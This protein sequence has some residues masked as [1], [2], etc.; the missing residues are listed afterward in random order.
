M[1]YLSVNNRSLETQ[2]RKLNIR[3]LTKEIETVKCQMPGHQRWRDRKR[4]KSERKR[5][6]TCSGCDSSL[7]FVVSSSEQAMETSANVNMLWLKIYW[8]NAHH[9]W[10]TGKACFILTGGENEEMWYGGRGDALLREI[11]KGKLRGSKH[12][13]SLPWAFS[14]NTTLESGRKLRPLR[15]IILPP[16]AAQLSTLCFSTKGSS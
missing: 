12:D 14:T 8:P 9:M 6:C 1:I 5:R 2:V 10:L 7:N 4:V 13:G 11:L 16:V 15:S 3:H